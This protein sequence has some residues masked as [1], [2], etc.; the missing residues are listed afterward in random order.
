MGKVI[1]LDD[2]TRPKAPKIGGVTNDQRQMG[3]RLALFH[4]YHLQQLQAIG[5]VMQRVAEGT[6]EPAQIGNAVSGMQMTSNYRYFG[7]LCGQECQALTAHHTIEDH[8][9]FPPLHAKGNAGL[10]KVIDRLREEH[11]V[12]HQTLDGLEAAAMAAIQNPRAETFALLKAIFLRLEKFVKSHFGYE[13]AELEEALG[14][15]GIEI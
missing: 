3:R 11:L 14:Y 10:K 1:L 8:Y 4:R 7:N 15:H 5:Q 13:E 12:I 2:T 6:D 9:I